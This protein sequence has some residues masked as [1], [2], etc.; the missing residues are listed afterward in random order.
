MRNDELEEQKLDL[1]A[2]EAFEAETVY[3][4]AQVKALENELRGS[5]ATAAAPQ[6]DKRLPV[7]DEYPGGGY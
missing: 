6:P 4:R 1:I 2:R 3:L 5:S 7:D